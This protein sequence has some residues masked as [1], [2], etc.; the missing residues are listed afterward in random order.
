MLRIGVWGSMG[1]VAA[2][3]TGC[4]CTGTLHATGGPCD[5]EEGMRP[6]ECDEACS[7][8]EPCA[9]GYYCG[10]SGICTAD[11]TAGEPGSCAAPAT[12][13]AD[14]RCVAPSAD[15]GGGFDGAGCAHVRV[16]ARRVTPNVILVV[17]QSGSMTSRFGGSNRWDGLRDS[18]MDDPD[19][20]VSSLQSVVRF[21][22]ALYSAEQPDDDEPVPGMCPLITWVPPAIDNYDAIDAVYGPADPIDETPT[23]ESLDAVIDLLR[24]TPDPSM[25]PTIFILATDGEPDTC[26]EPNPQN[27]QPESLAAAARAYSMGIRTFIISVGEGTVS[28]SHLQD[29]ANAG[30]CR[31]AGDPDAPYWVAGDD[32]GLRDALQDIIG[33]ELSCVVELS[34]RIQDLDEACSGVVNLNGRNLVCDDPNGWRVIDDT[35]IELVGEAC[36]ELQSGPGTRLDA[37]FPCGVILI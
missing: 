30:L 2:L 3:M 27:G 25:D 31:G 7:E 8:S 5:A 20:L 29:M 9:A 18:L 16:E 13:T 22:I 33:G 37:T 11:C 6:A 17:D 26:A 23:G 36:D 28:A 4:D 19:G 32:A 15:G 12:C 14:G 21:G 24:M 35:H 34:G 1:V 10:P